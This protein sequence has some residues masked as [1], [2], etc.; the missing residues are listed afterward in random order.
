MPVMT[1]SKEFLYWC[2]FE[3]QRRF[4]CDERSE[5]RNVAGMPRLDRRSPARV[6]ARKRLHNI[7]LKRLQVA[8]L[9][10]SAHSFNRVVR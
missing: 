9:V 3:D 4:R 1:V 6:T 5:L 10:G 8:E 7:C 2:E